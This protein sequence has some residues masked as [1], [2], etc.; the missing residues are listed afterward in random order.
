MFAVKVCIEKEF[1]LII[2]WSQPL[3]MIKMFSLLDI[4][5]SLSIL[6]IRRMILSLSTGGWFH[7]RPRP[8]PPRPRP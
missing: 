6:S 5:K 3:S 7:Q 1:K 8:E 4:V 2:D